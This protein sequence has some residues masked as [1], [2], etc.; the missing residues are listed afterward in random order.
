MINNGLIIYSQTKEDLLFWSWV[1]SELSKQKP[2]H[3]WLLI[4]PSLN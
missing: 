3:E 1:L 4:N 2:V